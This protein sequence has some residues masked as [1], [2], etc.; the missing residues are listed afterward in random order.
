MSDDP[1][2]IYSAYI[3]YENANPDIDVV[4]EDVAMQRNAGQNFVMKKRSLREVLD[5]PEFIVPEYQR[6]YSWEEEQHRELWSDLKKFI[7]GDI[8]SGSD[9]ISDVFFSTIYLASDEEKRRYEIIDG[10]QRLTT[11]HILLRAILE[12]LEEMEEEGGFDT[13]ETEKLFK[14]AKSQI[15]TILY[16]ESV[17]KIGKEPRLSLNKHDE[18]VFDALIRGPEAQVEYFS[19]CGG[20]DGRRSMATQVETVLENKLRVDDEVIDKINPD[21]DNFSRFIAVYDSNERL[22]NAYSFYRQRIRQTVESRETTEEKALALINLKNY[23]RRSYHV[24]EFI[25]REAEPGFRMRIFEVLNDRGVEL[26]KI[27]KMRATVVNTFFNEAESTKR[28]YIDKWEEIVVEFGTNTDDIDDYLSVYLSVVDEN[29]EEVGDASAELMN[30]FSTRNFETEV[31]PRFKNPERAKPFLSEAE[32]YLD[33]YTDLT[34]GRIEHGDIEDTENRLGESLAR[35][36]NLQTEQ[37]HPLILEL[38]RYAD[39]NDEGEELYRT[40]ETVE[41]L[42]LRRLFAG[43]DARVFEG[44]FIEAVHRFR[45][46][47]PEADDEGVGHEEVRRYLIDELQTEAPDMFGDRFLDTI[48]QR[49]SWDPADAKLVLGK[50]ANEWFRKE[51]YAVD[52]RLKMENIHLEHVFPQTFI[53]DIDNPVWLTEFFKLDESSADITDEIKEYI[54]LERK[55]QDELSESEIRRRDDIENFIT[56]RFVDDIGNYLLLSDKDNIRA[57]NLPFGDKMM[58]Y[59]NNEEDFEIIR[60]N[61]YFTQRNPSIDDEYHDRLT[62]SVG[63]SEEDGGD[64]EEE[65]MEHFNSFWTY[66]RMEKRRVG[67]LIDV[68]EHLGLDEVE[69]EFG[70]ESNPEGV[71]KRIEQ[72]TDEEFRNRMSL[73][74]F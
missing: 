57:S 2:D 56:N 69:D 17:D 64:I 67:V 58:D 9:D 38:Y 44:I 62:K 34:E 14:Q 21:R 24:G 68:L 6:L 11:V 72:K 37:W 36:N 70:L 71:R 30:A 27:D 52:R 43:V 40:L 66:E 3:D 73:R 28:E 31:Q 41:D 55:P 42:A 26:N 7:E 19:K 48:T 32:E 49:Q 74:S 33:Y 65:V 60:P 59:Y 1:Q 10:Q 61:R 18:E 46:I 16:D 25:I 5:K 4:T 15:K 39:E 45:G 23:I 63:E 47:S 50:I 13:L 12:Q 54:E 20:I 53:N 22:L 51:G 35:L 29:I 8:G